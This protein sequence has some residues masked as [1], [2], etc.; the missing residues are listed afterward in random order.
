MRSRPPQLVVVNSHGDVRSVALPHLD[1]AGLYYTGVLHGSRLCST[2]CADVT[3]VC[4]DA[5]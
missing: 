3:I 4:A 2:Y 5:P 1:P